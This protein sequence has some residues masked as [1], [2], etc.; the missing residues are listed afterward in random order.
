MGGGTFI[1]L[2]GGC[3]GPKSTK[4]VERGVAELPTILRIGRA[5]KGKFP[6]KSDKDTAWL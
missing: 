5:E 2:K 6:V 3:S 4:Q 1:W